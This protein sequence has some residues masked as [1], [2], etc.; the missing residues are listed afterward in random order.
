MKRSDS[1]RYFGE[2][3]V[4]LQE[5]SK[6][7]KD[8]DREQ[9]EEKSGLFATQ[10]LSIPRTW[11]VRGAKKALLF[12]A[13]FALTTTPLCINQKSAP[14]IVIN[15]VMFNP[16]GDD[17]GGEWIE[18]YNKGDAPHNLGGWTISTI[19]GQ[20]IAELPA[21]QIP[22]HAYLVVW[23]GE[24]TDDTDFS[25][26]SGTYYTGTTGAFLD[27]I[28]DAVALYEG[29]PNS[30][31]IVDFI[32][33]CAG[34]N[35]NPG[36][37]HEYAVAAGI[38]DSGAYLD[39]SFETSTTFVLDGET[40]GRNKS[41]DTTHSC[42]DWNDHGGMDAYFPT[43]GVKNAGPLFNSALGIKL[44]QLKANLLLVEEG[45][46]RVV[47]S[48]HTVTEVTETDTEV[49]II[50]DHTFSVEKNDT[51]TTF[52]GT[53]NYGWYRMSPTTWKEELNLTLNSASE[54]S[55]KYYL[56]YVREWTTEGLSHDVAVTE[57]IERTTLNGTETFDDTTL[58]RAILKDP[59]TYATTVTRDLSE[60]GT[61]RHFEF[62]MEETNISDAVMEGHTH[63]AM[64]SD[65]EEDVTIE[66]HYERTAEENYDFD[67][68]F[69]MASLCNPIPVANATYDQYDLNTGE[70]LYSLSEP[71]EFRVQQTDEEHFHVFWSFKLTNPT[72]GDVVMTGE[73]DF[74]VIVI[75]GEEFIK[76]TVTDGQGNVYQYCIDG[77]WVAAT[78]F[79]VGIVVGYVVS[80]LVT[81]RTPPILI[82]YT[83][84]VK[85]DCC[86]TLVELT[87]TV[88]DPDYWTHYDTDFVQAILIPDAEDVPA[89]EIPG[90]APRY[91]PPGGRVTAGKEHT[92][93]Y[94]LEHKKCTEEFQVRIILYDGA[95]NSSEYQ[96]S[97][98]VPAP[99]SMQPYCCDK[100]D[101][102]TY[103]CTDSCKIQC[104][105]IGPPNIESTFPMNGEINVPVNTRTIIINFCKSMNT[106]SVEEALTINPYPYPMGVKATWNSKNT[107]LTLVL[108]QDLHYDTTYVIEINSTARSHWDVTLPER[109]TFSFTTEKKPVPQE[110]DLVVTSVRAFPSGSIYTGDPVTFEVT[111][112]NGGMKNAGA[113][114]VALR[115]QNVA[116]IERDIKPLSVGETCK[117]TFTYT[118]QKSGRYLVQAEVDSHGAVSEILE[119]NN[120]SPPITVMILARNL[121]DLIVTHIK[122]YWKIYTSP[123]N[124]L[125]LY[126]VDFKVKNNGVSTKENIRI[127]VYLDRCQS[128]QFEKIGEKTIFGGLQSE[129]ERPLTIT[130][131]K[132]LE[133]DSM[134][135]IRVQV[136]PLDE[137]E[138]AEDENNWLDL[139]FP[140]ESNETEGCILGIPKRNPVEAVPSRR[141]KEDRYIFYQ[142]LI[143][144]GGIKCEEVYSKY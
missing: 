32:S 88:E 63:L 127:H 20:Q 30:K 121:P 118:F 26:G 104:P 28:E 82:D 5:S 3:E 18:L 8:S 98:T 40:I 80:V 1:T 23:I 48:G 81:D 119:N 130:C 21:W 74:E 47:D 67:L 128:G 37:A 140:S 120:L 17:I 129:E 43:P 19:D 91:R 14:Q 57:K 16:L 110:P 6:P 95:T 25:D 35:Y 103:E 141:V 83:A 77:F 114:S 55:E 38:W 68:I 78:V 2:P 107:V 69:N 94:D 85:G 65:I 111:V 84:E 29:T 117:V 46:Y 73:G 49:Y 132:E 7:R 113:C 66:T 51:Q 123:A 89:G 10:I 61:E 108:G 144:C 97:I 54:P 143:Y 96:L 102:E 87:L 58:L 137:I 122:A 36:A 126:Q 134:H 93:S 136:D 138:E 12:V 60:K 139:E 41:S 22:V 42:A 70:A 131:S 53:G 100:D 50:A 24:G 56:A 116:T 71:G 45:G 9:Y 125:E 72:E 142:N 59:D 62:T 92:F 133:T 105:E 13:V 115:I 112:A 79:I 86:K 11:I 52:Q 109:Y 27:N 101:V 90:N 33:W 64:T 15:E 76:G 34:S 135:K 124:C 31:T 99:Q 106:K 4:Y 44:T 75:N 39:T